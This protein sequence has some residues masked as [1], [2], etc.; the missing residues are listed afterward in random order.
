MFQT[1]Q[2]KLLKA[3]IA[4]P[5]IISSSSSPPAFLTPAPHQYVGAVF[6]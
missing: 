4:T 5:Q 3:V 1:K 6:A 2:P